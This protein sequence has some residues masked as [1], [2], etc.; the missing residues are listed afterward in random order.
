MTTTLVAAAASPWLVP[1]IDLLATRSPVTLWA[2]WLVPSFVPPAVARLWPRRVL[3]STAKVSQLVTSAPWFAAQTLPRLWARNSRARSLQLALA[4][5]RAL[6]WWTMQRL[7]REGLRAATPAHATPTIAACSLAAREPFAWA[8][9]RGMHTTLLVDVPHFAALHRDLDAAAMRFPNDRYLRHFRA[10]AWAIARQHAEFELADRILVR[11]PYA[12]ATI[13]ER[14]ALRVEHIDVCSI[15]PHG[16]I[17][18]RSQHAH[19]PLYL[20]GPAAARSGFAIAADAAAMVGRR[21]LAKANDATETHYR[22][23][24]AVDWITDEDSGIPAVATIV[25]P[26]LCEAFLHVQPAPGLAV[27]GSE[28]CAG[29][30]R[31]CLLEASALAAAVANELG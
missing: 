28:K 5:R 13:G 31:S 30:T 18:Q 25:A 8:K 21:L 14:R 23:H 24:P 22:N 15:K 9:A 10:P 27:I 6:A 1:M 26:A 7:Q 16:P 19:A 11:G 3:A 4:E 12:A 20:A 17:V 29:I 2:P